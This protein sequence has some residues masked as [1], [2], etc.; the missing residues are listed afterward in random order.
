[1]V[2]N[3]R[4]CRLVP[5]FWLAPAAVVLTV[6][7]AGCSTAID[8]VPTAM[9][10]LPSTVPQ[11]ATTPPDYPAVNVQPAQRD[12]KPLT[13]EEQKKLQDELSGIRDRQE[14]RAGVAPAKK[15]TEKATDPAKS[16]KA[17]KK[18]KESKGASEPRQSRT[19]TGVSD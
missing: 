14:V 18:P 7:L 10:G 8:L 16:A 3:A 12:I 17:A 9:G 5:G 13:A 1:M 11:R 15:D 19:A 4:P 2:L 6:V